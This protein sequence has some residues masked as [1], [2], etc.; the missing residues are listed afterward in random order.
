MPAYFQV[1]RDGGRLISWGGNVS[2]YGISDLHIGKPIDEQLHFMD[3]LLPLD[4]SPL[5]LSC[6]KTEF[7]I[8]ADIHVFPGDECD[9]IL[10]MDASQEEA[11]NTL[12]QQKTNELSLLRKKMFDGWGQIEAGD[13]IVGI[14]RKKIGLPEGES[15]R[16]VS[17]L[18]A[19]MRSFN[20]STEKEPPKEI[21][22][23]FEKS[24][25]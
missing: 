9:W 2:T 14:D 12:L 13:A 7:G 22:K 10:L 17:V 6:V 19:D 16:E 20:L 25:K 3:G 18:R 11:R 1:S 23:T 5:Y 15:R 24:F 21:F 4:Q 8:S